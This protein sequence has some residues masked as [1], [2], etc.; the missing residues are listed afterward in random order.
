MGKIKNLIKKSFI[1]PIYLEF[2]IWYK[3]N[4]KET[5][6]WYK[7]QYLIGLALN[8]W[9]IKVFYKNK[10]ENLKKYNSSK[11]I[12]RVLIIGSR[13]HYDP[14]HDN[15]GKE[16]S[17]S[18]IANILRN[19][20]KSFSENSENNE[21]IEIFYVHHSEA[22]ERKDL[23]ELDII[24]G[25]LSENFI[26]YGKKHK[27]AR[28]IL[29][30]VNSHPLFRLKVLLDEIKDLHKKLPFVEYASPYIFFQSIKYSDHI[31]AQGNKFVKKTFT[32]Y[33][34]KSEDITLIDSGVNKDILL[35]N[36]S[37]R[38]N[39]KLKILYAA[40]Q[41]NIRKGMHRVFQIWELFNK[42][43]TQEEASSAE[44]L[45][46]GKPDA[47][48][49]QDLNDFLHRNKNA[50]YHHRID[51]GSQEYRDILCSHDIIICP[52]LEEGQVGTVLECM[53]AGE[54]PIITPACGIEIT[55]KEGF[56]MP[57]H[58][59]IENTA[60]LLL[61]LVRN[62]KT[63]EEKSKNTRQFIEKYFDWSIFR[64]SIKKELNSM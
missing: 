45:V 58:L 49:E 54:V 20:Y 6:I 52:S 19:I 11:K 53:S 48:F 56:L 57:D 61:D 44:L 40:G 46:F 38:Q 64:E 62:P 35:P 30:L 27:E 17:Q 14:E 16:D 15:E 1:Y 29:Y 59:D 43:S 55:D 28:K 33:G 26:W 9:S 25:L 23:P 60:K 4:I 12:K 32:D 13:G 41:L 50:H 42:I 36:K 24:I 2:F 5:Y 8:N 34:F 10:K 21:E 37:L 18:A 39:N 63:L 51:A 47:Y 7:L 22:K 3:K 31:I